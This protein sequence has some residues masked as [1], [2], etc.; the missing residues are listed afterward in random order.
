MT[1]QNVPGASNVFIGPNLLTTQSAPGVITLTLDAANEA[2]I[3]IGRMRTS[4]GGSHT[5]DTTGSSSMFWRTSTVTFSNVGT[6]VKVGLGAVDTAVGPPGRAVNVADVITFDVSRSMVGG[7]GGITANSSQNHVPD[8]G[9]KTIASGDL[10][11]FC[12]Q[13]TARGGTDAI[14]VANLATHVSMQRPLITAFT[15]AA[16][17]A[18]SLV[19]N[20]FFT[21]SD[22]AT[23]WFDGAEVFT[24]LNTRTWNSASA[25]KEYGQLFNLPF[26]MKVSGA[27]FW[28]T[29][30]VDFDVVLYSDPLGTPVAEK[31][32]SID[33]NTV[34]SLNGRLM[35]ESFPS[36]YTTTANQNIG[37]VIKPGASSVS[38]YYKTLGAAGQRMS[39]VWGTSGYGISRASGAFANANSSL[40]HYYVGLVASAFDAGDG[41]SATGISRARAASGF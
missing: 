16:Y 23:G 30:D 37:L 35:R 40:D 25:T 26:P 11:A 7:G 22:G 15:G 41:G 8:T 36:S 18:A 10:V 19:P 33:G 32:V 39:D 38:A 13:M 9:S 5:I 31:T 17:V 3:M 12:V 29:P 20:C 2:V 24:T 34:G 6:T 27:Y 14:F 28:A 1:L 21:F 4:D